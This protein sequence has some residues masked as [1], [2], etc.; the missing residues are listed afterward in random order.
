MV[1]GQRGADRRVGFSQ[2]CIE[3]LQMEN[4]L[5]QILLSPE[6]LDI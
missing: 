6:R 5:C 3:Q 4:I 1:S 2:S